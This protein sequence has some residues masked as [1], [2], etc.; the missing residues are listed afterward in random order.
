M[1]IV[2]STPST[3]GTVAV[4]FRGAIG[5]DRVFVKAVIAP[6]DPEVGLPDPY[7]IEAL[8]FDA[9]HRPVKLSYPQAKALIAPVANII[10]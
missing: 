2:A 10:F 4:K 1:F 9:N 7:P 8:A 5:L 3:D 6:A